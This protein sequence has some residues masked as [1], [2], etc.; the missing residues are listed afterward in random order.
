MWPPAMVEMKNAGWIAAICIGSGLSLLMTACG[1]GGGSITTPPPVTTY[2]LTVNSTKPASGVAIVLAPGDKNSAA[3]GSTSFTRV[4]DAGTSVTLT[5]PSTSGGSTFSSWTGCSTTSTVTCSATLNANTTVTANYTAP[6]IAVT[7][8][9]P[10][11]S[12]EETSSSL[13]QLTAR[14][15][16]Q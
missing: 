9:P 4:Y 1:S 12:S 11:S 5:A 13:P 3:N 2:V 6:A 8:V 16:R 14:Q 15:V 10:P 7:P